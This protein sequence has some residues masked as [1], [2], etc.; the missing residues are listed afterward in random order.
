[1][2]DM[3]EVFNAMK[4]ASKEKRASN[5][6]SSATILDQAGIPYESKN[7][8]AHLIVDGCID[9]W[10]GTGK[11]IVRKTNKKGRGVRNMIRALQAEKQRQGCTNE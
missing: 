6:A 3:G 1:M 7:V 10:P 2:G 4:E 8:G 11:F 5:R 9:F